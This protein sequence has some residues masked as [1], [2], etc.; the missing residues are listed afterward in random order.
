MVAG[1]LLTGAS[2][3]GWVQVGPKPVG[4]AAVSSGYRC[5]S[6]TQIRF[7]YPRQWRALDSGAYGSLYS[8]L[9]WLS[10]Q[11]L[12]EPCSYTNT[13]H[14]VQ[15]RCDLP[16]RELNAD[17][18]LAQW[19]FGGRPGW[20][21][22]D[23]PGESIRVGGRPAKL[24]VIATGPYADSCH[25]LGGDK[26][27]NAWIARRAPHNYYAMIACLRGPALDS[28]EHAVRK[29]LSSARFPFG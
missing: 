21:L 8:T 14:G 3:A 6:T 13:D 19:G 17:G 22:S 26:V 27:M 2:N 24:A 10:T 15:V 20:S 28:L 7:A 25:Q 1:F 11:E 16:V 29:M 12:D 23:A 9:T 18:V 5:S 4:C